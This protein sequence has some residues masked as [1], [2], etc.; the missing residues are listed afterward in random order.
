MYRRHDSCIGGMT[1]ISMRRYVA[2]ICTFECNYR[3]PPT[4]PYIH[5]HARTHTNRRRSAARRD[6]ALAARSGGAHIVVSVAQN[7]RGSIDATLFNHA[8]QLHVSLPEILKRHYHR[9]FM[10]T[11]Q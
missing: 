9:Q 8:F 6:T 3:H 2:H 7:G 10:Q 1:H 4:H 11:F 5:M